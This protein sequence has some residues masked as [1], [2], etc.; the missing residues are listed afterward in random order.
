VTPFLYDSLV[1]LTIFNTLGQLVSTLVNGEEEA[2][3]HTV[4]FDGSN[5]ASGMYFYRLQAGSWV[6]TMSSLLMK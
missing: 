5:L 4:T 6:K 3:E 1:T 2:G